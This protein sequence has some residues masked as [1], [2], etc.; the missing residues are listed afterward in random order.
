MSPCVWP[1]IPILLARFSL[2]RRHRLP[3]RMTLGVAV[4][5]PVLF[6]F[7]GLA[8]AGIQAFVPFEP[9]IMRVFAVVLL[10]LS[11]G[12]LLF[13]AIAARVQ[14]LLSSFLRRSPSF[15]HSTKNEREPGFWNGVTLGF[16]LAG[17]WTPCIGIV[18]GGIIGLAAL[19]ASPIKTISLFFVYGCGVILPLILLGWG[20]TWIVQRIGWIARHQQRFEQGIGG[21]LL[22]LALLLATGG[23][24]VLQRWLA[25]LLPLPSL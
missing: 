4:S 21:I 5:F 9:R 18:L 1:L 13:P 16:M 23:D 7:V 15:S 11:G 24:H 10:I 25:P 19:G 14:V 22:V 3:F 17:V 2:G 6:T 8:I 12:T 20:S